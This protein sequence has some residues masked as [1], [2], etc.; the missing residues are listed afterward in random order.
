MADPIAML[1]EQRWRCSKCGEDVPD[2]RHVAFL[3]F[4][5][6]SLGWAPAERQSET[7]ADLIAAL[8]D[9]AA[10]QELIGPAERGH[11]IWWTEGGR[12]GVMGGWT[13]RHRPCGPVRLVEIETQELFVEWA[14]RG[15]KHAEA[16]R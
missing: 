12:P 15:G 5:G 1:T 9:G 10:F 11:T 4:G 14:L 16:S 2:S 3:A 8:A 13:R 6:L 7:P